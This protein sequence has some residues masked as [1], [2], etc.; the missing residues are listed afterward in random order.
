MAQGN[1][2][3]PEADNKFNDYINETAAYLLVTP[4]GGVSNFERLLLTAAENTQWQDFKDAWN[5]K[6]AIVVNNDS[7]NIRDSNAIEEKND[8][9][10]D[11]NDF[12]V[13]PAANLL[14][15]ISSSPE[16]TAVDRAKF[17]IKLRDDN[18]SARPQMTNSPFVDFK[19]EDGGIV[20]ITVRVESD[21]TRASMDPEADN[22]E[23]KYIITDVDATP[24][25]TADDCP[26][27]FI[28][29]SAIFRFE[30]AAN[31]PGK[32]MHAFLRWQNVTDLSKS[33]PYSGRETI[34]IGD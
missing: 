16:V 2:R 9:R 1:P 19:G 18:P 15:R 24:P 14:N 29:K 20:L 4:A 22:I 34:V 7:V 11:F 27:T 8:A 23:M 12:V 6:Y 31:M 10:D 28:S 32:R 17:N 33:G 5:T 25:A 3:I 30:A 26:S 21:S 13:A